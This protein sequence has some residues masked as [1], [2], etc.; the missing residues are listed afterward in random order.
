[1]RKLILLALLTIALVFPPSILAQTPTPS[2]LKT[3]NRLQA[4]ENVASQEQKLTFTRRE[5][6]RAYVTNMFAR[7]EAMVGR[8]E[9]LIARMEARLED[10][11][12]TS[13]K[14]KAKVESELEKAK[15]ILA[16]TKT[17][18]AEAK[19]TAGSLI[20]SQDPKEVFGDL[21]GQIAAIKKDLVAV[22]KILVQ[23]LGEMKGLRS[24][25]E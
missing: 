7:L 4:T 14:D 8:L 15:T 16:E 24:G 10:F 20:D 23:V 5:R 9:K 13:N 18:I 11:E 21:R 19:E 12:A 6:I 2:A 22:H 25:Q 3:K 1:M 17:D